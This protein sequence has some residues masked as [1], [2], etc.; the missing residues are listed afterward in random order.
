MN[1]W[2]PLGGAL[3]LGILVKGHLTSA[4][5]P[6]PITRKRG[7]QLSAAAWALLWSMAA[8]LGTTP[9]VLAKVMY[10]ESGLDPAARNPNGGAVGLNQFAPSGSRVPGHLGTFE[11]FV[12]NLTPDQYRQLPAE[13]QLP[14][15]EKFWKT[16]PASA[17]KTERDLYWVNFVPAT[18]VPNAPA[19]HDILAGLSP[20]LQSFIVKGNPG[21]AQGKSTILAGDLQSFLDRSTATGEFL[22]VLAQI[23]A[24][25][26]GQA[27]AM[28]GGV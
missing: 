22:D 14:Y 19:S 1:P 20:S 27:I 2:I 15:V 18:Y 26:P 21:I 24:H 10:T 5:K 17:M 23:A 3:A 13:A 28:G 11:T 7:P 8:D 6:A 9:Q 4:P 25:A 16:K 12:P